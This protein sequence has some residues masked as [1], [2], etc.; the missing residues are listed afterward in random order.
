[1]KIKSQ[2][3]ARIGA[4]VED[5]R[6]IAE[7]IEELARLGAQ[8]LI[9]T[10]LEAEID[11]FL[12]RDRYQRAAATPEARPGMRNGYQPVTVK[13]TAGPVA[14]ARPKLRGTTEAFASRLLGAGVSKSN[15]LESLCITGFVRGLSVR[16]VED[17]WRSGRR[18]LLVCPGGGLAERDVRA[19]RTWTCRYRFWRDVT[20]G[21]GELASRRV[22][23]PRRG[24]PRALPARS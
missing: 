6:D 16:D 13:T 19:S 23:P 24:A 17:R 2:I 18:V 20:L 21:E 14:L 10:A 5:G 4:L 8:L 22:A 12:G 3:D 1:V 15:A 11:E 7:I 9:Q